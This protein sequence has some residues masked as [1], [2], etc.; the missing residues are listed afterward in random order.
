MPLP[1]LQVIFVNFSHLT[2]LDSKK[3]LPSSPDKSIKDDGDDDPK[4]P[5]PR[6]PVQR[7]NRAHQQAPPRAGAPDGMLVPESGFRTMKETDRHR[8]DVDDLGDWVLS[9]RIYEK[10]VFHPDADVHRY[11]HLWNE[12]IWFRASR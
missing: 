3:Q 9:D 2:L 7:A 6:H 12:Y 4:E 11:S 5:P 8:I 1:D 10:T